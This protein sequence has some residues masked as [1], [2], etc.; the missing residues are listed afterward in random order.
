MS[1]SL[2]SEDQAVI[3]RLGDALR[4]LEQRRLVIRGAAG[5]CLP[6]EPKERQLSLSR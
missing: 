4:T 6:E 3:A 2:G 5:W 1:T